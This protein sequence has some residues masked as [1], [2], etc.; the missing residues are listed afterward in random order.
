M[1]PHDPAPRYDVVV[2]GA[3]VAG[4]S[5]ALLLARGGLHVLV[6]D[7]VAH[8]RDTLSTHALMRGGVL[9]LAHWGVL[10]AVKAAGTPRIGRTTFHYGPRVVPVEIEPDGDIDGLYAPRRTVLDAI[11]ADAAAD[12]GA[13]LRYG[14][15][16]EDVRRTPNGHVT[17]VVVRDEEGVRRSIRTDLVVGADGM[18][19]RVARRVGARATRTTTHATASVY[20]H[21][22]GMPE[23]G[24]HWCFEDGLAAGSIP[25][26][27]AE[28]CVFVSLPAARFHAVRG[29]NL[30]EV[31]LDVLR[32][33]APELFERARGAGGL[34]RLRAFPG[35]P[36]FLREA[37]GPGW[38]L[39]GDA[40][41]F[42]DPLTAHGMTD[43]L[44]DAELLARAVLAGRRGPEIFD[45]ALLAYPRLRDVL[46]EGVFEVT[47][48]IASF[49]W[50]L[51]EVAKLHRV[52]SREMKAEVEWLRRSRDGMRF[53]A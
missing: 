32:R 24:Y 8:G 17:H 37:A 52:L 42:K 15:A 33:T 47:D 9:Q 14:W 31:F 29:R 35:A 5:T 23:D 19:S 46:S 3:R 25:T 30:Q 34:E 28:A 53:A 20:A 22:P 16:F 11:L 38:A 49:A 13:E 48:R 21:L 40:G 7:P 44:R 1:A 51:E 50:S 12:V 18:R 43:A 4:A 36:G 10:D 27:D 39:V 45:D 2:A 6:V 26:N 41:Y